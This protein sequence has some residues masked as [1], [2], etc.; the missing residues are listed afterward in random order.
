MKKLFTF[1]AAGLCIFGA[2][3]EEVDGINYEFDSS[4]MTATVT[5]CASTVT[6]LNIP[7]KVSFGGADYS[8]TSIAASAFKFNTDIVSV[9]TASI[10]TMGE[11]A[12][13]GCSKLAELKLNK[14]LEAIPYRAFYGC[15]PLSNI[16][17]PEGV[18]TVGQEAFYNCKDMMT[19]SLPS[20]LQSMDGKV[21]DLASSY[22]VPSGV[23]VTCAAVVPPTLNGATF[24]TGIANNGKLYVPA[25]SIDAYKAI[26]GWKFGYGNSIFAMPEPEPET[27]E[28]SDTD[29]VV[30]NN[31]VVTDIDN[32]LWYYGWWGA[33]INFNAENPDGDG[34]VFEFKSDSGNA[35]ASGGINMHSPLN[36][37]ILNG[38]TLNFDW[39]ANV[40]GATY[41][42]RLTA[43]TACERDYTFTVEADQVGKWNT[44]SIPLTEGVYADVAEKWAQNYNNGD[45][46]VF[47]ISMTTAP[48]DA[49]IYFN[50]VYYS[51][52]DYNWEAPIIEIPAPETVPVPEQAESDVV[53]ILSKYGSANYNLGGWGQATIEEKM[54]ID[55]APVVFLRNFNYQGW[56][57][58]PA[59]NASEC[60]YLH[61]D[62]WTA[63]ENVRFGFTPISPANGANA[64]REK[65]YI[66]SEVKTGEWNSYD[67][68]L[69]YFTENMEYPVEFNDIFQF[70][71]DQ[72]TYY[73][74]YIANVY[75]YKSENGGGGEDP[76]QP[77]QPT[78]GGTYTDS[79][80]G[81]YTQNMGE[82]VDYAYTF[83]YTIVYNEDKT[84]DMK[85]KFNWTENAP[86][87]GGDGIFATI[88]GVDSVNG[89]QGEFMT[90]AKTFE[91]GQTLTITFG[92]GV[93]LGNVEIQV[94]YTVG[95]SNTTPDEPQT[96]TGN[97]TAQAD[98]NMGMLPEPELGDVEE[99]EVTAT[100]DA[101]SGKLTI[102]NFADSNAIVF[103]VDVEK[104]SISANG[105][106]LAFE[107]DGVSY[108][109]HNLGSEEDGPV[110][111]IYSSTDEQGTQ[112]T[113]LLIDPWGEGGDYPDFG[114]FS[115]VIYYN[116]VVILNFTIEGLASEPGV[117]IDEVAYEVHETNVDLIINYTVSNLPEGARVWAIVKDL[118]ANEDGSLPEDVEE[119]AGSNLQ[120]YTVT[121][122][123]AAP[124]F[125]VATT[126]KYVI[127]LVAKDAEGN[128]IA[129]DVYEMEPISVTTGINGISADSD[130]QV[131]YFNLQ[132][133]E[134]AN[135]DGGVYIKVE[136]NKA[137]KVIL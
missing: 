36:T 21:F 106:Q 51:N 38:A 37:G 85:G 113:K 123:D 89:T 10:T 87:G 108:Y 2:S 72:G 110:G 33:S 68:P 28:P 97:M 116:T 9:T 76:D 42:I 130:A 58:A 3:A 45:G 23:Q 100:Y 112:I 79:I 62:M 49:V 120:S 25:Q 30:Y 78:I 114:F 63:A 92:T 137:V 118:A 53:S 77:D 17:V 98:M 44:I 55:E 128:E 132:G 56:E 75:F 115:P 40:P 4:A 134:V 52:V 47:G 32:G 136:G 41:A 71:F 127:T 48:A 19:I 69:S 88:P 101:T 26:S 80:E 65:S 133:V 8:V 131:R 34:K 20:T 125:E 104:N 81:S 11:Q 66:V 94:P 124:S 6:D 111:K 27:W 126:H 109:Y 31:G 24:K 1:L 93:A 135:P 84:L 129:S 15:L 82:P 86:V 67:V 74:C 122:E 59:I 64:N 50:K 46:Y 95:S 13:Y 91:A 83:D 96:I 121:M 22:R 105:G 16:V 90:T 119:E 54:T 60:N 29:F 39:Y 103:S 57:F 12:F 35:A 7:A 61:V 43:S 102:N 14:G 5:G 73:D 107:E 117:A 18:T 70:K 99:F